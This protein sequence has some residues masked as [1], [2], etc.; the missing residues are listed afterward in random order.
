MTNS[1]LQT[2][3][4]SRCRDLAL[5]APD[6][7]HRAGYRN[8]AKGL[9]RLEA[10]RNCDLASSRGLIA[11][12]PEALD[13]P[14]DSIADAVEETHREIHEREEQAW[15]AAFKPHAIIITE[16]EIPTQIVIALLVGAPRHL[17]IDFDLSKDRSTFISQTLRELELRLQRFNGLI[18]FF[19]AAIGVIV[20]FAPER[21]VRYDIDGNAVE[22]LKG[23]YRTDEAYVQIGR[24][25]LSADEVFFAK[26]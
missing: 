7:I 12:L 11:K 21:A 23:A 6:L 15:R 8:T 4:E 10:L 13:L 19:G 16:R 25:R 2:L 14:P 9:R 26:S 18:P 22:I 24:R 5:T 3:I 17:R 20:N 1:S